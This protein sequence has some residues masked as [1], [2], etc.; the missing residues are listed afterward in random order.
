[1]QIA[2]EAHRLWLLNQGRRLL[3]FS[4]MRASWTVFARWTEWGETSESR[5]GRYINRSHDSQL[6]A[7]TL[8]SAF[9]DVMS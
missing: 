9:R 7:R 8:F 6:R 4:K 5:S 1:M 2:T 3:N